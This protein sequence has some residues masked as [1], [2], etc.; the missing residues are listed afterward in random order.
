[1]LNRKILPTDYE[2][3]SY[4]IHCQI[5]ITNRT[6]SSTVCCEM[7]C[8]NSYLG[9]I[10]RKWLIKDLYALGKRGTEKKSKETVI[11]NF[12]DRGLEEI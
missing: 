5:S 11:F 12:Q 7:L 8:K 9:S 4:K 3:I 2:L 1:M 6:V 10:P